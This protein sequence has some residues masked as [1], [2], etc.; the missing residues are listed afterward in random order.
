MKLL[1]VSVR[2]I[3]RISEVDLNTEGYNLY[4]FGGKN[5]AGKSSALTAILLALCGKR[6]F[7]WPDIAL[8]EGENEGTVTLKLS[9]DEE[10]HESDHLTVELKLKRKRTGQVVEE[11][12]ILDSTGEE[13][14]EPRQLLKKLYALRGFDPLAFERAKK[15]EQAKILRKL[16]GLDFDELEKKRK[17][18]YDERTAVNKEGTSKASQLGAIVVPPGTPNEPVSASELLAELEAARATNAAVCNELDD[19]ALSLST[20]KHEEE[21]LIAEEEKLR[22]RLAEIDARRK[23]IDESIDGMQERYEKAKAAPLVDLAEITERI[24]SA[25]ATNRAVEAKR[26]HADLDGELTTLRAKSQN[27]SDAI[28]SIDAEKQKRMEE[29]KWPLPGMSLDDSGVLMNG[30]PFEQASK[31]QRVLASVQV[32]MALN[33]KL[34]LLICQDGNDLDDDTMAALDKALRDND[35]QMLLEVVTRSAEDEARC[36]VVFKDGAAAKK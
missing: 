25:D 17:E 16:L 34:R 12:R 19:A 20:T 35:F 10:L 6:D 26:R 3:M 8:K 5:G 4:L 2:N 22:A 28:K 23:H 11:F 30:L 9:G 18:L 36:A 24:K 27:L 7:D 33:P 13:A 15:D 1:S 21:K 32:G 31:A 14:P 29:A